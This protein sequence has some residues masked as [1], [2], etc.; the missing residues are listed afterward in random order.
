M[1]VLV[2]ILNEIVISKF[3]Y[4][5]GI[6]MIVEIVKGNIVFKRVI[7]IVIVGM[8]VIGIVQIVYWIVIVI[9]IVID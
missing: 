1:I 5:I 7:W 4:G 6:E 3:D 9:K 2:G 8:I